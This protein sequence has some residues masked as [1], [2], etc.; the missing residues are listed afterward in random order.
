MTELGLQTSLPR[1]EISRSTLVFFIKSNPIFLRFGNNQGMQTV[2]LALSGA[3]VIF[4]ALGLLLK[5][6]SKL[7]IYQKLQLAGIGKPS[8][9]GLPFW[10]A[11]RGSFRLFA[12]AGEPVVLRKQGADFIKIR[13]FLEGE[14]L[15]QPDS[16]S[17]QSPGFSGYYANH[18]IKLCAKHDFIQVLC[19]V[20]S[21]ITL[22][23]EKGSAPFDINARR[24]RINFGDFTLSFECN[25]EYRTDTL[26]D[27]ILF[28]I[29][30]ASKITLDFSSLG[31]QPLTSL[32]TRNLA[33]GLF[34]LPRLDSLKALPNFA[35]L[36]NAGLAGD[37]AR[38]CLATQSFVINQNQGAATL[39]LSEKG[40]TKWVYLIRSARETT[41]CDIF[42]NMEIRVKTNGWSGLSCLWGQV[43]INF[44]SPDFEIQPTGILNFNLNLNFIMPCKKMDVAKTLLQSMEGIQGRPLKDRRMAKFMLGCLPLAMSENS[45][46]AAFVRGML[47]YI[48]HNGLR[49]EMLFF[50]QNYEQMF[51]N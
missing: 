20:H 4:A 42:T 46:D 11:A 39:N 13:V 9:M 45:S 21:T 1:V 50:L 24:D 49:R 23:L 22:V 28:E 44:E 34:G 35:E 29:S 36:P 40:F 15:L 5:S 17:Q 26:E 37:F 41:V 47:P 2:L 38:K 12:R 43:M 32:Q 48:R 18:S 6:R 7:K 25:G 19:T 8:N 14:E 10:V 30:F 27:S 51:Y 16:Y 31:L 33:R 3:G